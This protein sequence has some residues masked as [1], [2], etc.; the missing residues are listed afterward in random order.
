M[1]SPLKNK[2]WKIYLLIILIVNFSI[3]VFL[4]KGT[5]LFAFSDYQAYLEAVDRI[6]NHGHIPVLAGNFLF[7]ISYLGY[8][9]KYLTGNL[10]LFFYFN[11]LAGTLTTL[12]V[13]G[14]LVKITEDVKPGLFVAVILTLYT[15]FMVFSS[16][17]YTPVIMLLLSGLFILFIYH[18]LTAETP[19]KR[20]FN[21]V[22]LLFI[23]LLT[24]IFKPE[25][26]L[27]PF[28]LLI[29]SL[30]FRRKN[31]VLAHRIFNISLILLAG[32]VF[33]TGIKHL[34]QSEESV[35]RN[36]FVFFGHTEYGGDGGEGSFVYPENEERY[37]R[38]WNDY[39]LAH[40]LKN[41]DLKDRNRFQ[42]F[43]IKKFILHQPHKWIRLQF[44][45]FFRTFGI[46]PESTSFKI[47]YTGI[48]KSDIGLTA[49]IVVVPVAL[50]I[51]SFLLFFDYQ[52]IKTCF[53]L[54]HRKEDVSEGKVDNGKTAFMYVYALLF[55][56]YVFITVFLGHY[57]ERYRLPVIVLFVVPFLAY[58][59]SGF[60]RNQLHNKISMSIKGICLLLFLIIWIFQATNAIRNQERLRDAI[61]TAERQKVLSKA[62]VYF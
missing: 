47:L 5:S 15:E 57:Q 37:I 56:Y 28:F 10:D 24:F 60:D 34:T 54:F 32:T 58:F 25:L 2:Y 53:S 41:P 6:S 23:F 45:K 3:R 50:I 48:C 7:A 43:E 31:K 22:L 40:D 4:Y 55:F 61:E 39:L 35:I 26:M 12:L 44:T 1:I 9:S 51:V 52:K 27:F 33:M 14:M 30:I 29:F 46:V 20:S 62:I 18:F 11:C 13:S 16:V 17:F 8:V 36:D 38:A 59:I 21:M 49:I 19:V 42:V